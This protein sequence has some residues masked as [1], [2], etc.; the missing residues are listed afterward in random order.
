VEDILFGIELPATAV[1]AVGLLVTFIVAVFG[2]GNLTNLFTDA[3]KKLDKKLEGFAG[4]EMLDA[5]QEAKL[6]G[7]IA[8]VVVFAV[9][10][11]LG[12]AATQWITP[13][14]ETLDGVGAW[15]VIVAGWTF[16][17]KVYADRKRAGL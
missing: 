6:G 11:V 2:I 9:A 1:E 12:F 16:S 4:A 3:L 10:A 7:L 13:L 15:P 14:A 5:A 17:R 8:E